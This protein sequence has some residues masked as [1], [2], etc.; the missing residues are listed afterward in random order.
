MPE[1]VSPYN[2]DKTASEILEVAIYLQKQIQD[3][4]YTLKDLQLALDL[5]HKLNEE[6]K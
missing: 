3:N 5:V 2:P 1:H 4:N 6:K